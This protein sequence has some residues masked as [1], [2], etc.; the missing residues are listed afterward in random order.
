MAKSIWTET[1]EE[2]LQRIRRKKRKTYLSYEKDLIRYAQQVGKLKKEIDDIDSELS[3]LKW[4][5]C[6]EEN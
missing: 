2:R 1:E 3:K 4:Q 5:K 6:K